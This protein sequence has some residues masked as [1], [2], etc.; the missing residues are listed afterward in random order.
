MF[1]QAMLGLL[2]RNPHNVSAL[3]SRDCFNMATPTTTP[4]DR[5]NLSTGP[6]SGSASGSN[7]TS[8]TNPVSSVTATSPTPA[9]PTS[10]PTASVES[11]PPSTPTAQ[12]VQPPMSTNPAHPVQPSKKWKWR[13][14][15]NTSVATWI[16]LAIA[17]AA[18]VGFL[19]FEL[20]SKDPE[21][22][23]VWKARNAFHQ[24]CIMEF[25]SG[26]ER[27]SPACSDELS[28]FAQPPPISKRQTTIAIEENPS[29]WTAF[30]GFRTFFYLVSAWGLTKLNSVY[31]LSRRME[32][33]NFALG[34]T[35][36]VCATVSVVVT[37][38]SA[39]F[40]KGSPMVTLKSVDE[41]HI[42]TE[43][44][45]F[46]P[47]SLMGLAKFGRPGGGAA[48]GLLI[49][50]FGCGV[51]RVYDMLSRDQDYYR[52]P[53]VPSRSHRALISRDTYNVCLLPL[54]IVPICCVPTWLSISALC[55]TFAT[56]ET[57]ILVGRRVGI[58]PTTPILWMVFQTMLSSYMAFFLTWTPL[59]LDLL[60]RLLISSVQNDNTQRMRTL[61]FKTAILSLPAAGTALNISRQNIRGFALIGTFAAYV[62]LCLK[63]SIHFTK[64]YSYMAIIYA[65]DH[66]HSVWLDSYVRCCAMPF[67]AAPDE[68]N[69][70]VHEGGEIPSWL[71][72]AVFA[73]CLR[74]E[75]SFSYQ[76]L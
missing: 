1:K 16:G 5:P 29:Q 39:D 53:A 3:P 12:T 33:P 26:S 60:T 14:I 13:G 17:L 44:L 32:A 63:S 71:L 42:L 65:F 54:A 7:S 31:I 74:S 75:R 45:F 64:Q 24:T 70:G 67:E 20:A 57:L 30:Y 66:A 47:K 25:T 50:F 61:T 48:F 9:H 2:A 62:Q 41:V 55:C 68:L 6:I 58:R 23:D 18:F 19:Y 73:K 46:N 38:F 37:A 28:N 35:R 56:Y 10:T 11:S 76:S 52:T 36:Y 21:P 69:H 4:A 49:M 15:F 59:I 34:L 22:L 8:E 51:F 72:E 40:S 27:R 43:G